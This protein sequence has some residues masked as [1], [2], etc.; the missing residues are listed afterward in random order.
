[1]EKMGI[2]NQ[3]FVADKVYTDRLRATQ[4][5]IFHAVDDEALEEKM[6]Q[7]LIKMT[8]D[9]DN[10]GFSTKNIQIHV[11]ESGFVFCSITYIVDI[12]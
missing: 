9:K 8:R 10:N 3:K 12:K 6:N 2:N 5:K 1:M 7:W 11:N 4:V